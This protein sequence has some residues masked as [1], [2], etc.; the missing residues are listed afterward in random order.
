[1]SFRPKIVMRPNSRHMISLAHT[2]IKTVA[3]FSPG[4]TSE[5]LSYFLLCLSSLSLHSHTRGILY[6]ISARKEGRKKAQT[7][8]LKNLR[9]REN[10]AVS[11]ILFVLG[12]LLFFLA[13][14]NGLGC[15]FVE[16]ISLLFTS[17]DLSLLK[18]WKQGARARILQIQKKSK[19][20]RTKNDPIMLAAL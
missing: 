1:M 8:S 16:L 6:L 17:L 11:F 19:I 5:V 14:Q 18:R 9:E 15:L 13:L 10:S 3:F 12:P 7:I 4:R 20:T 2:A